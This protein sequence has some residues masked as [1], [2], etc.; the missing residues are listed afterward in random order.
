M[1]CAR[2]EVAFSVPHLSPQESGCSAHQPV[3]QIQLKVIG[4]H[5]RTILT[6]RANVIIFYPEIWLKKRYLQTATAIFRR[7]NRHSGLS[8]RNF[9]WAVTAIDHWPASIAFIHLWLTFGLYLSITV[10]SIFIKQLQVKSAFLPLSAHIYICSC[11]FEMGLS[12]NEQPRNIE[13]HQGTSTDMQVVSRLQS[14]S[15]LS[16]HWMKVDQYC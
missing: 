12:R 10:L 5:L 6:R 16:I 4:P 8:G 14:D 9:D 2:W 15:L 1:A 3:Q 7:K 13:R 11:N